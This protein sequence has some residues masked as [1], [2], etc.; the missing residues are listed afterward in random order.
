M[1]V[2]TGFYIIN[3][4]TVIFLSSYQYPG[5]QEVRRSSVPMSFGYG[6]IFHI[7]HNTAAIFNVPATLA[8][9]MVS[10]YYLCVIIRSMSMS[11][12]LPSVLS[13]TMGEDEKPYVAMIFIN[14]CAVFVAIVILI[15]V[16][17]YP[18]MVLGIYA[19]SSYG[20]YFNYFAIFSAYIIFYDNYNDKQH[21]FQSPL[22]KYGAYLGIFIVAA[23]PLLNNFPWH[24]YMIA[25][26]V[27]FICALIAISIG[28][29]RYQ[30]RVQRFSPEEEKVFFVNFII[31]CTCLLFVLLVFV[32]DPVLL[33]LLNIANRKHREAI[34][35]RRHHQ[36]QHPHSPH[37]SSH[38]SSLTF[39]SFAFSSAL[40]ASPRH[41]QTRG[42]SGIVRSDSGDRQHSGSVVHHFNFNHPVPTLALP[43]LSHARYNAPPLE[44]SA[45]S[46]NLV[47]E[48][49]R[50]DLEDQSNGNQHS[51]SNDG[52]NSR[53]DTNN[54]NNV[55]NSN[56][57]TNQSSWWK[58]S[59]FFWTQPSRA[60]S[61]G[62]TTESNSISD[63]RRNSNSISR[64]STHYSNLSSALSLSSSAAVV[65]ITEESAEML[66]MHSSK[67]SAQSTSEVISL[68][69]P[70]T[71]QVKPQPHE[72]DTPDDRSLMT[73]MLVQFN[74]AT[75][76]ELDEPI[77]SSYS[78][79]PT[80][81]DD[82]GINNHSH[83][84]SVHSLHS[85]PSTHALLADD[86]TVLFYPVEPLDEEEQAGVQLFQR[87]Q[88]D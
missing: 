27:S 75:E 39:S 72:V 25:P 6:N 24:P 18:A 16:I 19:F 62:L 78:L 55:T 14:V 35:H 7:S 88:S 53:N 42:A 32:L 44:M 54:N 82:A 21:A 66:L 63:F 76:A 10:T 30:S 46:S 31:K 79:K 56:N 12:L 20:L 13:K 33:V 70:A 67:G 36:A 52:S 2:A 85:C 15:G 17:E 73:Q 23:L 71:V 26:L 51:G 80:A 83:N 1:M 22:G 74:A 48:K 8:S 5:T 77:V 9:I 11:G 4:S 28:Y 86:K 34:K 3:F 37:S 65:P 29:I 69:I 68:A 43:P 61:S 40:R 81:D 38:S 45:I 64:R 84:H 50:N 59:S 47:H 57:K 58:R 87:M 60:P 49:D 41:A